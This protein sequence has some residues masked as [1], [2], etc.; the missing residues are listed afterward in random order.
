MIF[1][2]IDMFFGPLGTRNFKLIPCFFFQL[3]LCSSLLNLLSFVVML[4][5]GCEQQI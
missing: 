4:T 3:F 5:L 1:H 2:A